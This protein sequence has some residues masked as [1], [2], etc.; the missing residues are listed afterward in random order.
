M[1]YSTLCDDLQTATT[2]NAASDI[3]T[4]GFS[5]KSGMDCQ[6]SGYA[7]RS[8]FRW[9]Q[10]AW[11]PISPAL[12]TRFSDTWVPL[13]RWNLSVSAEVVERTVVR[14][15]L[16]PTLLALQTALRCAYEPLFNV[17]GPITCACSPLSSGT[18]CFAQSLSTI[19]VGVSRFCKGFPQRGVQFGAV[20]TE[21]TEASLPR[22]LFCVELSLQVVPVAQFQLNRTVVA[23][24]PFLQLLLSSGNSYAV[25]RNSFGNYVGQLVTDGVLLNVS[26]IEF[27]GSKNKTTARIEASAGTPVALCVRPRNLVVSR[28]EFPLLDFAVST[29]FVNFVPLRVTSYIVDGRY[30]ATVNASGY[31]FPIAL[32]SNWEAEQSPFFGNE[33][34]EIY[35]WILMGLYWAVF[36]LAVSAVI[37]QTVVTGCDVG[38]QKV[39]CGL[40]ALFSLIRAIYFLLFALGTISR[41]AASGSTW[42]AILLGDLPTYVFF[43]I[44]TVLIMFFANLN[45]VRKQ[46]TKG[47]NFLGR[48]LIPFIAINV[49]LYVFFVVVIVLGA[50]LTDPG[51]VDT[52]NK[53]YKC[54]VAGIAFTAVVFFLVF[55]IGVLLKMRAGVKMRH[56]SVSARKSAAS[57]GGTNSG[58]DSDGGPSESVSSSQ[59]LRRLSFK[60]R[61]GSVGPSSSAGS[62]TPLVKMSILISVCSFA[63]LTQ[64]ALLL[65]L[66]FAQTDLSIIPVIF[67]LYI[68]IEVIPCIV[69][70]LVLYLPSKEMRSKWKATTASTSA[71]SPTMSK[72]TV[73]SKD[74]ISM[75]VRSGSMVSVSADAD[76][77]LPTELQYS[78]SAVKIAVS[79]DDE[80]E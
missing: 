29:D 11:G 69:I 57:G 48:L 67:A 71:R 32:R 8:S 56:R 21:L 33:D 22:G 79:G 20:Y 24:D 58:N 26:L 19:E 27:A 16:E 63:L 62:S 17:I 35:L 76:A 70:V 40:V 72:G 23:S 30:C 42:V 54:I 66:A 80:M 46:M 1:S 55:G 77:S 36:A 65:Y 64:V 53:V 78:T 6:T 15:A 31:Y 18:S 74:D 75:E 50:T 25:V 28:V 13:N 44:Y 52:V 12:F 14:A 5:P 47:R 68:V 2:C 61:R 49:F 73:S 41:L 3:L 60:Q 7:S 34:L 38:M 39:L 59:T 4:S 9:Q 37:V 51:A 43:S 45:V 10:G